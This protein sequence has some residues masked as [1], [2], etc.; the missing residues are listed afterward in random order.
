MESFS[1]VFIDTYDPLRAGSIDGTDEN[2][3]DKAITRALQAKFKPNKFVQGKPQCTVIVSRLGPNT[4]EET[5]VKK[6]AEFGDIVNA[7]LIKDLVTGFSK[8][9]C[10]IEYKDDYQARNAVRNGRDMIIDDYEVLVEQEKG[11][12]MKGWIP[13]RLGGGLGG[14]R[15]SGQLRFGGIDRPFRRPIL[16]QN[17]GFKANA[18]ANEHSERH[19]SSKRRE[20]RKINRERHDYKREDRSRDK[21][22]YRR[23]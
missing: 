1:P 17:D 21:S 19:D 9:Y 5:L 3:H 4:T 16:K 23:K 13:R 18:F 7:R 22:Y 10:F 14:K 6:M 20:D 2:P 15:E 12:L 11:R 8:C